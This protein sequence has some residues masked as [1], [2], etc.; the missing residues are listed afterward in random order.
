MALLSLGSWLSPAQTVFLDFNTPGQYTGN[1]NPWNDANGADGGNYAFMESSTAGVAGS[2]GVSV[3]QSTDTTATFIGGSWDF[4]TNGA[5]LTLSVMVKANGQTS[6]NKVQL[7][8]LNVYNN[9]LNNNSGVAFERFRTIPSSALNERTMRR[10]HFK[11]PIRG[12]GF[13]CWWCRSDCNPPQLRL[14]FFCRSTWR[15]RCSGALFLSTYVW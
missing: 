1:F 10:P 5:V 13:Q 11:T 2:G 14:S 8:F 7:G 6:A 12:C 4:S 3:F 15:T 9:G